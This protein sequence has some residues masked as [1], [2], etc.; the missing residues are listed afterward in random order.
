[1]L[2][3][4]VSQGFSAILR[5]KRLR[6]ARF[7]G[8]LACETFAFR[9]VFRRF[10]MRNAC[11][12][13]GFSAISHANACISQGFLPIWHVIFVKNHPKSLEIDEDGQAKVELTPPPG[14]ILALGTRLH[15]EK[16][17]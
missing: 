16:L 11:V 14:L 5:A 12:S 4:C 10:C 8:D 3:A 15:K 9:K 6:F 17:S 2:N 1:M 13:Q 7:F